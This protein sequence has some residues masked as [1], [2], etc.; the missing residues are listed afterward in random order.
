MALV[1]QFLTEIRGFVL[2]QDGDRLRN[3]LLV[4]PNAPLHYLKLKAELGSGFRDKSDVLET[5]VDNCLP[6]EDDV[7]EGRGSPWAGFRSFVR[8]YLAYWRDV[9]FD[10]PVALYELLSSLLT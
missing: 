7:P 1:A 5:M 10:D 9:D 3:Y 4:E 2:T 6:D 8:E